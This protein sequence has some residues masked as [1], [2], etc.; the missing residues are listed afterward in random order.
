MRFRLDD[1]VNVL[2]VELSDNPVEKTIEIQEGILADFDENNRLTGIEIL[3]GD[4]INQTLRN[5]NGEIRIPEIFP[6]S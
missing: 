3:N 1:E 5:H 6:A 4:S 2:Y